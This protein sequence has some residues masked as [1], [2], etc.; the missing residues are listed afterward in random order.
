M[1][2][3]TFNALK[4]YRHRVESLNTSTVHKNDWISET[5]SGSSLT[6]QFLPSF[7]SLLFSSSITDTAEKSLRRD[8]IVAQIDYKVYTTAFGERMSLSNRGKWINLPVCV[9]L[10]QTHSW[11][12]V[13]CSTFLYLWPSIQKLPIKPLICVFLIRL[14]DW[15]WGLRWGIDMRVPS[16]ACRVVCNTTAQWVHAYCVKVLFIMQWMFTGCSFRTT[17]V[18]RRQTS[19]PWSD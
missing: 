15:V 13:F 16:R 8:Y 4:T 10:N 1:F 9:W 14:P 6:S 11:L 19:S 17:S 5:L 7:P 18:F 12:H 3:D 2:L